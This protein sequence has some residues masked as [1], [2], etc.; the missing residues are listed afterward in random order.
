MVGVTLGL[1]HALGEGF[2]LVLFPDMRAL[3]IAS[4]LSSS[5]D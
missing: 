4:S 5:Y 3:P 1:A 2:A